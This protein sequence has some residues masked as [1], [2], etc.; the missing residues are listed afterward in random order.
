MNID[1][2]LSKEKVEELL[3]RP[4]SED[5]YKEIVSKVLYQMLEENEQ[6]NE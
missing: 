5:E 4:I 1:N 3:E 2:R 6:S